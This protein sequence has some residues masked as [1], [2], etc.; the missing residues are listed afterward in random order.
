MVTTG[1]I[2][3]G[4]IISSAFVATTNEQVD[5]LAAE[6]SRIEV[7]R[8]KTLVK[9]DAANN[10]IAV[11]AAERDV[12][13]QNAEWFANIVPTLN[14]GDKISNLSFGVKPEANDQSSEFRLAN[15]VWVVEGSRRFPMTGGD[16]LW[17]PEGNFWVRLESKSGDDPTDPSDPNKKLRT[18]SF[19]YDERPSNTEDPGTVRYLGGDRRYYEE[20]GKW[21]P[22]T[23]GSSDCVQLT[24]HYESRRPGFTS[25]KYVDMEVLL[26]SNNTC[27]TAGRI[28]VDG[29]IVVQTKVG[30][31]F[32]ERP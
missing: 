15:V 18:V 6:K 22:G 12:Y 13:K 11:L 30:E 20:K 17:V 3:G 14:L 28:V 23:R 19:H 10:Q 31:K 5:Q 7:D 21:D 9:L 27:P 8:D 4:M 24:V 26:Y 32:D 1:L 16:I 25:P 29:R 2:V